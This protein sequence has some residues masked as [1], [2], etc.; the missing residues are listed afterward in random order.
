MSILKKFDHIGVVVKD[1]QQTMDALS[2]YFG[3]ECRDL[4]EIEDAG[5]RV[6]FY[7]LGTAQ[8][9]FIEFQKPMDDVDPLVIQ[10][11]PGVQHIAFQV[12]DFEEALIRLTARGLKLVRGFPREGAHGRVAF[13]YPTKKLEL[14]IEIC[15]ARGPLDT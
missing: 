10:P 6:A 11:V 3:L 13:F 5:I 12:E 15:E 14:L 8:I 4:T 1:L 2:S 9:E 7:P